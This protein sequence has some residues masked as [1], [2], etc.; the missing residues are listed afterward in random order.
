MVKEIVE[1]LN[2]RETGLY[3]DGTAGSGGHTREMLKRLGPRGRVLAIDRDRDAINRIAKLAK[4][5]KRVDTAHAN[6]ADMC[7]V[8]DTHDVGRA[9]GIVLDLGISSEQL[10]ADHR[11]FSFD[12][13]GPLDMR[14]DQESGLTAKDIVNTY[15]EQA[16]SMLIR[17]WGEEPG[18]RRI[19]RAIVRARS[20]QEITTTTQLAK[21]VTDAVGGRRGRQHPA[22]RTF[23]ALRIVVNKELDYVERGLEAGIELLNEGGRIAVVSFHSIE[24]RAVKRCFK[25]HEGR[26]VSLP[27][28]GESWEGKTPTLSIVTKRPI[29]PSQ[30]ERE[31][32]PRS[33]SAKLRVAERIAD[34]KDGEA[35]S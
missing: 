30:E 1:L 8:A 11:G 2:I 17:E 35:R 27:E 16:L 7:E 20:Q 21:I 23:Q 14:M 31:R 3:I 34:R 25:V 29:T 13:D 9:D 5:D 32:N 6:Y 22:T 24:D 12:R 19:A 18:A 15:S 26:L 10:H 4:E 28:G 33:R